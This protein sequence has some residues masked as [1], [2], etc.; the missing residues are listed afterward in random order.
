M[1]TSIALSTLPVG[2]VL[3]T[4]HKDW[5]PTPRL[6]LPFMIRGRAMQTV[7]PGNQVRGFTQRH[8]PTQQLLVQLQPLA[9]ACSY[10]AN[11]SKVL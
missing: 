9:L 1:V 7:S 5:L 3:M 4:V 11:K 2:A 6:R 8:L 10:L